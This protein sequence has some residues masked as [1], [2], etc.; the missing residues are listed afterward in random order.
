MPGWRRSAPRCSVNG[1]QLLTGTRG[2]E[3]QP[4]KQGSRS[5]SAEPVSIT[6]VISSTLKAFFLSNQRHGCPSVQEGA[7]DGAPPPSLM[8]CSLQQESPHSKLFG[9]GLPVWHHLKLL[10]CNYP[11]ISADLHQQINKNMSVSVELVQCS[12]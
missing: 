9:P 12:Q 3:L 2:P 1:D 8:S 5:V 10:F 7:C 6:S 4:D 11:L